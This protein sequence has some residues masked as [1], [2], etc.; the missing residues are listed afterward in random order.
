MSVIGLIYIVVQT[1]GSLWIFF[2]HP[3]GSDIAVGW[4]ALLL[5]I[6]PRLVHFPV[7]MAAVWPVVTSEFV[8]NDVRNM[9]LSSQFV[10][11]YQLPTIIC[12]YPFILF[13]EPMAAAVGQVPPLWLLL[14]IAFSVPAS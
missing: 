4:I 9:Y 7:Q 14:S 1:V 3:R 6:G 8:D 13:R 10:S 2:S 5:F 11:L 12:V